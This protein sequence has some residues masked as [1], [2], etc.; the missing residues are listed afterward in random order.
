MLGW[1]PALRH[2]ARLPSSII[3]RV[4]RACWH[5]CGKQQG[6]MKLSIFRACPRVRTNHMK[7]AVHPAQ[8]F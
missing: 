1:T 6:H 2:N 7:S 4:V 5:A 8:T 3:R